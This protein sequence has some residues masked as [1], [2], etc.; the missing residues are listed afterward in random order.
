MAASESVLRRAGAQRYGEAAR[1]GGTALAE[2]SFGADPKQT[3]HC[4]STAHA[5]G[6][7]YA[8]NRFPRAPNLIEVLTNS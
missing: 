6:V 3:A 8:H 1:Q 7:A 5:S 2:V 4:Y